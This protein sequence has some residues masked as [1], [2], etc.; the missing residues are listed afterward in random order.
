MKINSL[1]VAREKLVPCSTGGSMKPLCVLTAW[2]QYS[3]PN[4]HIIPNMYHQITWKQCGEKE[5]V[6]E[7]H[8]FDYFNLS[9]QSASYMS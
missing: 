5:W 4:K 1:G 6:S 8:L 7:S 2:K 9:H 3:R